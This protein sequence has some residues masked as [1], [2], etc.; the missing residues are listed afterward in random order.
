MS[1]I[2]K[3]PSGYHIIK[4]TDRKAATNPTLAEK[5]EEI[6]AL[7]VEQEIQSLAPS[8]LQELRANAKITNTLETEAA[9]AQ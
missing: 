8:W 4:V 2:V 6:R 7:L 5:K 3:S 9:P 1:G